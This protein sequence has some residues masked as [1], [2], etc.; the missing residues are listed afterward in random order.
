MVAWYTPADAREYHSRIAVGP[1][2]APSD[3]TYIARY[4]CVL[5][6]NVARRRVRATD[7]QVASV[8]TLLV[9]GHEMSPVVVFVLAIANSVTGRKGSIPF[10]R[11]PLIVIVCYVGR[12]PWGTIE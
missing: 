6:A 10:K 2:Q 11:Y 3:I 4:Q 5:F 12:G 1:P 8:R 9:F 7:G